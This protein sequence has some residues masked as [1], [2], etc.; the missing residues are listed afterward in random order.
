MT[1]FYEAYGNIYVNITN[2][3]P[4]ACE[5]CVRNEEDGVGEGNNLW[6]EREPT[7]EEIKAE[8]DKLD[9]SKYKEVVFCGFGEPTERLEDL[10][11]TSRYIKSKCD[12]KIRL[13]TNGLSDLIFNKKT[14]PMLKG[15]IDIVSVSLNA[16]NSKLYNERCHPKFGEKSFESMLNFVRD[17]KDNV[18]EV[19]VTVVDCISKEEIEE[20]RKIAKDLGVTYRVRE[21]I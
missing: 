10:I 17:C 12:K 9:M 15:A 7:L 16:P 2:K 3:C 6:L 5:F 11:E 1:V 21:L 4:C 13:N 8:F 18:P 20:C 19:I 14:A